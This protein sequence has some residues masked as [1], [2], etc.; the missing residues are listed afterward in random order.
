MLIRIGSIPIGLNR[1]GLNLAGPN[2]VEP[3]LIQPNLAGAGPDWVSQPARE[4]PSGYGLGVAVMP[5]TGPAV[6]I[7]ALAGDA[8]TLRRRLC[9]PASGAAQLRSVRQR[10]ASG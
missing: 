9:L 1:I 4:I 8:L 2:R 7:T 10:G 3:N 6:L 5:L